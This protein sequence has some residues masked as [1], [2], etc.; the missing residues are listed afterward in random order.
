MNAEEQEI[1]DILKANGET[2]ISVTDISK[3]LG[4]G[5]KFDEDRN[6]ARPILRRME[7][8]GLLESNPFGEYRLLPST[9]SAS[10]SAASKGVGFKQALKTP[11][12]SLGDTTII[13]LED[14]QK[15][16]AAS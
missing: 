4:R 1:Y 6:W 2:F 5:R 12:V 9:A 11:G 16:D 14:V 3:R 13:C 7:M 8:D 10:T 15:A